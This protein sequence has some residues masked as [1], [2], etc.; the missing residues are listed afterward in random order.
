MIDRNPGRFMDIWQAT[1]GDFV[2]TTQRVHRS[3]GSASR[4]VL[5]VL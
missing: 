5:P 1:D 3:A 4:I 2:R